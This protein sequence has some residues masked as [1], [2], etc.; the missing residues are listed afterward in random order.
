VDFS[1]KIH[2]FAIRRSANSG[3][4]EDYR[5]GREDAEVVIVEFSDFQCP[6]CAGGAEFLGSLVEKY[7]DEILLVFKNYP[8]DRHCNPA[9]KRRFHEHA[10]DIAVMARCAGAQGKFWEF[11]DLA[12]AQQ[13]P[14]SGDKIRSWAAEVG[15]SNSQIDACL[16]REDEFL[17]KIGEDIFEGEKLGVQ[18][19]PTIFLNGRKLLSYDYQALTRDVER[20]LSSLDSGPV[21]RDPL[22]EIKDFI[23]SEKAILV[24]VRE[25]DEWNS[26]H[27]EGAMSFPMSRLQDAKRG[28]KFAALPSNK[29][30]Y[31]YCGTGDR[32]KLAARVLKALKYEVRPLPISLKELA[33]GG[34]ELTEGVGDSG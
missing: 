7:E 28:Q 29:V 4:G 32:A 26:G 30:L 10:C 2:E 1:L 18:G 25:T 15:L 21:V 3:L 22:R 11:H 24:D 27:L 12:F 23:A 20:I 17:R 34:F 9:I 13:R 6:G 14:M 16:A 8:L 19:T 5:K 31:T 33:D